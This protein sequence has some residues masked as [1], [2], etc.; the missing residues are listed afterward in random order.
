MSPLGGERAPISE[1][2]YNGARVIIDDTLV[3]EI[4]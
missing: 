2:Q 3:K 1:H 4:V